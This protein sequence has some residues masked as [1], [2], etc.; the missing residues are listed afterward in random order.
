MSGLPLLPIHAVMPEVLAHL[1]AGDRLVVQAPPGAGKTTAIPLA[2]LGQPWATGRLVLIQP[3]RLAV[4]NAARRVSSL[5]GEP[6]GQTIGYRTR[7]DSRTSA[8]TRIEVVTGGIYLRM[9][10]EDPTLAGISAVLF[11]EFHERSL[12]ADLGVALT[13]DAQRGLRDD[14]D[15]LRVVAMSATL[16]GEGLSAWLEAPLVRSEGRCFAVED[17]YL[18]PPNRNELEQHTA[19]VIRQAAREEQGNILVF[20]PGFREIRRVERFLEEA[21]LGEGWQVYPLHASLAP[22]LQ[23][24][25]IRPTPA[26]QRKVVLA[27]NVAETSVTIEGIRVVIDAGQVRVARFDERR[28]MDVLVTERVSQAS[29]EQRRG[30]AGRLS[31]GVCYRLWGKDEQGL[32]RAFADP[33]ILVADLLPFA[34]ELALW[35]VREPSDIPLPTLPNAEAYARAR[36]L[37]AEL[38]ALDAQGRVTPRGREMAGLGLHPRLAALVLAGRDQGLASCACAL[39]AILS[40]DDPLR[41]QPGDPQCDIGLRLALWQQGGGDSRRGAFERL[42]QLARQL[43][44]RLRVKFSDSEVD[45]P[46]AGALLAHAFPDRVAQRR[47]DSRHR[48][49]LANGRGVQLGNADSLAGSDYLVVLDISGQGHEPHARLAARVSLEEVRSTLAAHIHNEA[50]IEWSEARGAMEVDQR[51]CLGAL[52]LRRERLPKPWPPAVAEAF[53]AVLRERGI[54]RLPWRDNALSLRGRLQWL[55]QCAPERWPD[56]SDEALLASLGEWLGPFL[57]DVYSLSALEQVDLHAALL[58]LLEWSQQQA[59]EKEAPASWPLPTGRAVTIDY[60]HPGGPRLSA[61]LTECYGLKQ[62]PTLLCGQKLLIELLSPADRPIQLTPDLA[63]FWAGSYKEVA[64]EMR[65]RYP[66]HFWPEDPANAQATAR[67]KKY[68]DAH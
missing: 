19:R 21:A 15:P 66:K 65:G 67:T 68:M 2:L 23:E 57:T 28:G 44:Q 1:A 38:D 36:E 62:T 49:L 7:F 14:A 17:R 10:Q 37:L 11:D 64:K 33:E 56:V 35:G 8:A 61:R 32:Q 4:Y 39:A 45:H 22:E 50:C 27:T 9:L 52:V 55:H 31:E 54:G 6:V 59:L 43:A 51:Q 46:E 26:G 53:L 40:E 3:R 34:L 25:A 29:A 20:L 12:E 16:D 24:A 58:S 13:L 30:R 60:A 5:L 41:S 47:P 18:A 48:Y 42:K 63:Q